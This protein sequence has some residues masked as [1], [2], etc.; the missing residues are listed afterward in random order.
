MQNDGS[1]MEESL[2]EQYDQVV[3]YIANSNFREACRI[4]ATYRWEIEFAVA[5]GLCLLRRDLTAAALEIFRELLDRKAFGELSHENQQRL[6]GNYVCALIL[7]GDS[8]AAE[9]ALGMVDAPERRQRLQL[10]ML[11]PV[12]SGTRLIV[13]ELLERASRAAA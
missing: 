10:L 3:L 13:G 2:D 4:A 12:D 6:F 5:E 7:N 9:L 8:V 11:R 1:F